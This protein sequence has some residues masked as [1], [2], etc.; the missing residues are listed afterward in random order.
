[1]QF[2]N[3]LKHYLKH[4]LKEETWDAIGSL[5]AAESFSARLHC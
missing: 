1:M 5:R 2:A 3:Y 4:Y